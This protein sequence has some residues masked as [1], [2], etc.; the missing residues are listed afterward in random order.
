[1]ISPNTRVGI[2]GTGRALGA[3]RRVQDDAKE[4]GGNAESLQ[5]L[6]IEHYLRSE[7]RAVD[8][9]VRAVED[10]LSN[11]NLDPSEVDL[12]L[13][14]VD[15]VSDYLSW[16]ESAA[17]ARAA[18]L[19]SARC[20]LLTQGCASGIMVIDRANQELICT[21][22]EVAVVVAVNRHSDIHRSR[23]RMFDAVMSDGAGAAVLRR[24]A[25]G[26][27]WLGLIHQT[28]S[29]HV[30][31]HRLPW[32]GALSP[33]APSD[34]DP[35]RTVNGREQVIDLFGDSPAALLTLTEDLTTMPARV[36]VEASERYA[37]N[38]RLDVL[39]H[40]HDSPQSIRSLADSVG[41]DPRQSSARYSAAW[42]HMGCADQLVAFDAMR[43]EEGL[44][45]GS[46]VAF[47]TY[48]TGM[49]WL[50]GLVEI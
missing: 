41:V 1:M 12:L 4:Y 31:L 22:A 36:I 8:L 25:S 2:V 49:H 37:P 32:G 27:R 10:A 43:R 6:E 5:A 42:G 13:V 26:P 28:R 11:A 14:A 30:D 16:D 9:A 34:W 48:S 45:V 40:T 39:L 47:S 21:D 38:R 15:D 19:S 23:M 50:C 17:V 46:V 7:E 35:K 44:A 3:Q 18:G 20:Q 33:H 29:A 24:G